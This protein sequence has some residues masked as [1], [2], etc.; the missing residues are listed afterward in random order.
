MRYT[1]PHYY[2]KFHCTAAACPATCCAG[3]QI[4]IDQK[5]QKKYKD[6]RGPFGNR[7]KNSINWKEGVFDQYAGRCA[8][9][10]EKN[11]CD[12]YTEAGPKM[13]CAT[14]RKYPRHIEEFENE[15]EISLSMSCPEA[16]RLI[17]GE[18][19]KLTFLLTEDKKEEELEE[20]DSLLYGALQ[21]TRTVL[22]ELMQNRKED[23]FLRMARTLALTHDV[24]SRIDAQRLFE[25]EELL[26]RAKKPASLDKCRQKIRKHQEKA[27]LSETELCRAQ[28]ELPGEWEVL[29][30][31]WYTD[32][33]KWKTML[34]Q[35]CPESYQTWKRTFRQQ[36]VISSEEYEQMMV[37]YLFTYFCGAVYDGDA[38]AKTK[39]AVVST[40]IWEEI[41][42]AR[43]IEQCFHVSFEDKL[44]AAW[45]YSRELEHS[46]PNLIQM[47][48]L[49]DFRLEAE[50]GSLMGQ[51]A[52]A[53]EQ[54]QKEM[55]IGPQL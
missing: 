37:Y 33:Q 47:E 4:V 32:R 35:S 20:F 25:V 21:D 18:K 40:L 19:E 36:E 51:L 5:S 16:A 8:F 28:M 11:L 15:R 29:D 24:Q 6:Y 1:V 26:A 54:R 52:A 9:L 44:R 23:V 3:W 49:M 39:M 46:D 48:N 50:C 22:I 55:G 14:C 45:R 27:I 43:W 13:L 34:Y 10:N 53:S 2:K 38:L 7:L 42:F 17:L 41:V 31:E 12:I 30:E